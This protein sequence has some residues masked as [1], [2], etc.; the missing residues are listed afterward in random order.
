MGRQEA[1]HK[2]ESGGHGKKYGCADARNTIKRKKDREIYSDS[3]G[4]TSV[5]QPGEPT[6]EERVD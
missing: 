2:Y 3:V 4:E 6:E 5:G 1:R